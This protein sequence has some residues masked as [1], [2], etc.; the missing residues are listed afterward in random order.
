MYQSPFGSFCA[1]GIDDQVATLYGAKSLV[2]GRVAAWP[3]SSTSGALAVPCSRLTA[4]ISSW[5][6][7]AGLAELILMPYFLLK[8]LRMAP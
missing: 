6:L 4:L 8:V 1:A 5:L 7:P 2:L 3:M